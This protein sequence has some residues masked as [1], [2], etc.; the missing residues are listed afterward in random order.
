MQPDGARSLPKAPIKENVTVGD[1]L[2]V[3]ANYKAP[4]GPART[5]T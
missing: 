3:E 4:A 2:H 1:Y 5:P